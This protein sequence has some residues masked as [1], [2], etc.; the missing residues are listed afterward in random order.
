MR[1]TGTVVL[2]RYIAPGTYTVKGYISSYQDGRT[3][4][5]A[6]KSVVIDRDHAAKTDLYCQEE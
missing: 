5:T 2:Q 1:P 3:A 4:C 6:T